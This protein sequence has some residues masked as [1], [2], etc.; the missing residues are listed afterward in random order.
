MT[1]S[2]QEAVE[3]VAKRRKISEDEAALIVAEEYAEVATIED[4]GYDESL[5]LDD[6]D[7][8]E[9]WLREYAPAAGRT[10]KIDEDRSPAGVIQ[11]QA[12]RMEA[13][14]SGDR[15]RMLSKRTSM[16]LGMDR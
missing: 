10:I 9:A 5:L 6:A 12:D 4:E 2:F 15:Y 14:R 13:R 1:T 7:A 8:T 16:W 11:A 3:A